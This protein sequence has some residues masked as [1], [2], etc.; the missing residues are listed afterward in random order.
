MGRYFIV[1]FRWLLLLLV[2]LAIEKSLDSL[3]VKVTSPHNQFFLTQRI[4]LPASFDETLGSLFSSDYH[5]YVCGFLQTIV[6]LL[7]ILRYFLT[8]IEPVTE[9][10]RN[11]GRID[12]TSDWQTR[13]DRVGMPRLLMVI[14]VCMVEFTL[15]IHAAL[16]LPSTVQWLTFLAYLAIF[17]LCTFLDRKSV[18]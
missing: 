1:V 6:I 3:T 9:G 7:I 14:F 11:N 18:V 13:L 4:S 12:F 16:A 10:C 8:V 5:G 15:I 17:D 2:A